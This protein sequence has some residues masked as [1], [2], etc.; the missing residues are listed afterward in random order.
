MIYFVSWETDIWV[1]KEKNSVVVEKIY[2]SKKQPELN[3][4]VKANCALKI[5]IFRYFAF[6]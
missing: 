1:E 4:N 6:F 3:E 2:I 5:I